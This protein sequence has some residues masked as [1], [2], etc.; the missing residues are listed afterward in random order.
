MLIEE[1]VVTTTPEAED[2]EG[3]ET[4]AP[5]SND[6]LDAIEDLEARA[7]AKR[8]RA[9]DRRK[10]KEEPKTVEPSAYA[11]KDDLKRMAT[12]EAKKLVAPEVKALWDELTAVPLGGFDPLDAESIAKNMQTRYQVYL[13]DNP[14]DENDPTAVFTASANIPGGGAGKTA[15]KSESK[16]LP[17]YREPTQPTEWYK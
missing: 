6:P 5:A 3:E 8:L 11:T 9:I 1:T 17:G 12:I 15:P 2:E 7:E 10:V 16:P 14:A 4:P 13:L